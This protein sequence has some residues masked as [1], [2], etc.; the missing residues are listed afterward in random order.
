[1]KASLGSIAALLVVTLAVLSSA[2]IIPIEEEGPRVPIFDTP[3][4]IPIEIPFPPLDPPKDYVLVGADNFSNPYNG[5][6]STAEANSLLCILNLGLPQPRGLPA[7][8]TTPGGALKNSWSGGKLFIVPKV[9][10]TKLTSEIFA[11]AICSGYGAQIF[12]VHGARMAEFHDGDNAA[13]WAGWGFW[14]EALKQP[15]HGRHTFDGRLWVKIN[16]QSSNPWDNG[17]GE[18]MALTFMKKAEVRL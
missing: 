2:E 7:A 6:T 3:I 12:N 1:M 17:G 15:I 10:G 9:E 16:G 13:G 18:R 14:A 5:D 4:E 8:V 11:D